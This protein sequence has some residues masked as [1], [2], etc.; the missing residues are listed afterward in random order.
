MSVRV[1]LLLGVCSAY[2]SHAAGSSEAV[3]QQLTCT[4]KYEFLQNNPVTALCVMEAELNHPNLPSGLADGVSRRH[5]RD[6]LAKCGEREEVYFPGQG[7]LIKDGTPALCK[8]NQYCMNLHGEN[9]TTKCTYSDKPYG[10][11]ECEKIREKI[12]SGSLVVGCFRGAHALHAV[13][14]NSVNCNVAGAAP[15]VYTAEIRDSGLPNTLFDIVIDQEG[16]IFAPKTYPFNRGKMTCTFIKD[17]E[18]ASLKSALEGPASIE[19][20]WD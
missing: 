3:A 7:T 16:T 14:V 4:E 12:A 13:S 10:P 18:S 11:G 15:G 17:I 19:S 9:V 2:L 6:C 20:I 5:M 1:L 8:C